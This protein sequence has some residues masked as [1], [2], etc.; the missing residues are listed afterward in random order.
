MLL[1]NSSACWCC[2]YMRA[3][4][5]AIFLNWVLFCLIPTSVR[6]E[7]TLEL[8]LHSNLEYRTVVSVVVE[9]AGE[10]LHIC[11][12]DDRL[13]EEAID[14]IPLDA[15]PG[16]FATIDPDRIGAEV[17]LH[18]PTVV[19]CASDD[20]CNSPSRCIDYT[21]G[22]PSWTAADPSS[23][24]CAIPVSIAPTDNASLGVCD[25]PLLA[26][27]PIIF[28]TNESG[29][30]EIDFVGESSTLLDDPP[31]TRFFDVSVYDEQMDL[32]I[33]GRVFAREWRLLSRLPTP[34]LEFDL[35]LAP[36]NFSTDAFQ[37]L[38]LKRLGQ[39]FVSIIANQQG[40]PDADY[41]GSFCEYFDSTGSEGVIC[42]ERGQGSRALPS[43]ELR[44]FLSAPNQT[45]RLEPGSINEL[46]F[47]DE[48]GTFSISP[49]GDGNQDELTLSFRSSHRGMWR[50]WVDL[51]N[52]QT[53]NNANEI[54]AV[55]PMVSGENSF[56]WAGTESQ[57]S[58]IPNGQYE[59]S[60]FFSFGEKHLLLAGAES[61]QV[62]AY[63]PNDEPM[64]LSW[65]DTTIPELPDP[66]F[67]L[68]LADTEPMPREWRILENTEPAPGVL[69][70]SWL[71]EEIIQIEDARCRRC[72]ASTR[73]TI[74]DIDED[75][76]SDFDG[77][78]DPE[79]DVN[80]NGRIDPGETD[81][82]DPDTD[83]DL[84]GDRE[85]TEGRSSPVNPDSDQDG[86]NDGIEN[87]NKDGD[88]QPGETDPINQDTDGDTLP[89]GEEDANSNGIVDP[90]ETDPRVPDTD[91]DGMRDDIDPFP[92]ASSGDLV[93]T[94]VLAGRPD[95]GV[96]AFGLEIN[97]ADRANTDEYSEPWIL[98]CQCDSATNR[99][100]PP[101]LLLFGV[102]FFGIS[103]KRNSVSP[104]A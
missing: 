73:L 12:S 18:P 28:E 23:N 40:I 63:S 81:P 46:R 72:D 41:F 32:P 91:G 42:T 51:D 82:L 27:S 36:Q 95:G 21:T 7:G 9:T 68:A 86:L 64:P 88:F 47:E 57:G 75:P 67:V 100:T 34:D 50:F 17:V 103:F 6:A 90:G 25:S 33:D 101:F 16:D 11:S 29:V 14:N 84:I 31:S 93:D 78:T 49:N 96:D 37:R 71:A 92:T 22:R 60:L 44:L 62:E 77:L 35:F 58:P 15:A 97:Q 10:W 45:V 5:N 30:W 79:E 74:G 69:R 89:D 70:D 39:R 4:T 1:D 80:G 76:D 13:Q 53:I 61:A 104:S 3:R 54:V 38:S 8:G 99:R 66:S 19:A 85:E 65:N 52:D 43:A 48:V 2:H 87:T 20:D 26:E 83:D 55:A 59:Y 98:G 94:Y 24:R 56:V 102:V